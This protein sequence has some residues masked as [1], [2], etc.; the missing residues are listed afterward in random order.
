MAQPLQAGWRAPTQVPV[1]EDPNRQA[2]LLKA[3]AAQQKKAAAMTAPSVAL[4]GQFSG[5][6]FA[7]L[8]QTLKVLQQSRGG[9]GRRGGGG[10]YTGG[11]GQPGT[12]AGYLGDANNIRQLARRIEKRGWDVNELEGFGGTGQVSSGHTDNSQHYAGTAM[13]ITGDRLKKL[14]KALMRS[15]G[16][17]MGA[18]TR[19]P[20]GGHSSHLHAGFAGRKDLRAAEMIQDKT[21]YFFG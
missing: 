2:D 10:G 20:Y 14:F 21:G 18:V 19:S 12:L 1:E 17:G 15:F 16:P 11:G 13:D 6:S 4:Q 7:P 8:M 9:R 5:Q 3:L